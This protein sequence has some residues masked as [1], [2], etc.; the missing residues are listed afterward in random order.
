VGKLRKAGW[1]GLLQTARVGP[2]TVSATCPPEPWASLIPGSEAPPG[3]IGVRCWND[4]A[5]DLH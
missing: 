3:G 2:Q 4:K 5:L 1:I